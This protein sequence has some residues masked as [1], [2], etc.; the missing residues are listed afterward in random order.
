[1]KEGKGI[2]VFSR[3]NSLK[4]WLEN[5]GIEF[6]DRIHLISDA[7]SIIPGFSIDKDKIEFFIH[8]PFAKRIEDNLIDRNA[9]S[10]IL[11]ATLQSEEQETRLLI[12]GDTDYEVL[13]DIVNITKA[14]KNE[15]RLQWDIYDIP[16]HCSYLALNNEK[17]DDKT[18]PAS[19]V[20]WLFEQG[21][22]GGILVSCSKVIPKNDDDAQ[23]PH[24]Q[25]ANYYKDVAKNISGEFRVTMEY[26]TKDSPSPL[27]IKV[28]SFGATLSKSITSGSF[29]V[30]TR[31]APRA[32]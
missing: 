15:Q 8:S 27:I 29:N 23:P 22:K 7:G 2:R 6:K 9:D 5:E 24:R 1:M 32:G 18:E 13:A 20:K 21:N 3:P 10:I 26:P 28:D 25:A 14:H 17:G 11:H 16:H 19:E 30:T 31:N 4:E 12:I